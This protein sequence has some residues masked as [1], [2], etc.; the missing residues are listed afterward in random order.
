MANKIKKWRLSNLRKQFQKYAFPGFKVTHGPFITVEDKMYM[1]VGQN[2]F[3]SPLYS[4]FDV[5][6]L[7][8]ERADEQT[9]EMVFVYSSMIQITSYLK[10]L[11]NKVEKSRANERTLNDDLWMG[12]DIEWMV[13]SRFK[14]EYGEDFNKLKRINR[15]ILPLFQEL[16]TRAEE[17]SKSENLTIDSF[18]D[19]TQAWSTFWKGY[20]ERMSFLFTFRN[21]LQ[22]KNIQEETMAGSGFY[23]VYQE[24]NAIYSI[25]SESIPME[26][27]FIKDIDDLIVCTA[28]LG[29]VQPEKKYETGVKPIWNISYRFFSQVYKLIKYIFPVPI[30]LVFLGVLS[31]YEL[32]KI[33]LVFITFLLPYLIN[34]NVLK[35]LLKKQ[36]QQKRIKLLGRL[37]IVQTKYQQAFFAWKHAE[38]E[39]QRTT[40]CYEFQAKTARVQ[41]ILMGTG[42]VIFLFG[43]V[44]RQAV[45]E[46]T[47]W[48]I[49][50]GAGLIVLGAFLLK[51]S[52]MNIQVWPDKIIVGN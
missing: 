46:Y 40:H 17:L 43:I 16:Q 15:K 41:N 52:W 8:G 13:R 30:I 9:A 23:H 24:A 7:N 22:E 26:S 51:W 14:K 20:E 5:L 4:H 21:F 39:R 47:M 2:M 38:E 3:Q 6:D 50:I 44:T 34:K 31:T 19:F 48:Y 49:G 42:L 33:A 35:S 10:Q 29:R 18:Q 28:Q 32:V 11:E 37:P 45:Q 27:P 25:F 1:V 12:I 36:M